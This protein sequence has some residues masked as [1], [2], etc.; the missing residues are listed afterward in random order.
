MRQADISMTR[1]LP[2]TALDLARATDMA[3]PAKQRGLRFDRQGNYTGPC[4]RCGGTDRFAIS[5]RKQAFNCRG[6]GGK[7][8]GAIALVMFLD[9]VEFRTAVEMLTGLCTDRAVRPSLPTVDNDGHRQLVTREFTSDDSNRD[10]AL[11]IWRQAHPPRRTPVQRHLERRGLCLPSSDVV[12][13]HPGCPFAGMR[14]PAMIALVRNIITNEP[15]AIHRTALDRDGNKIGVVGAD[16]NARERMALG[17]VNGGA[18]KLTDDAEVM[19]AL[20]VGEGIETALSLQLLAEWYGSPVWSLL[21][22]DGIRRLPALPGIESLVVAIDHDA[23]DVKSGRRP[24]QDAATAV[25]RRWRAAGREVRLV[26]PTVQGEDINDV[27]QGRE[28]PHG[29]VPNL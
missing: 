13:F 20:G 7:G 22:K 8:H 14:T 28:F 19:N 12:R 11:D 25:T 29:R 26:W 18:I 1:R 2:N 17:S 9:G 5:L 10:R 3:I 21:S 6:C 24:G 4:P 15:Q 16:G 27:V 23:R